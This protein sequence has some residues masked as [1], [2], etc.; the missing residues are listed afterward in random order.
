VS[1]DG[2]CTALQN[3]Q[4]FGR[5][6]VFATIYVLEV[7]RQPKEGGDNRPQVAMEHSHLPEIKRSRSMNYEVG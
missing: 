2:V 6:R 4:H 7:H 3:R 5:L 1:G